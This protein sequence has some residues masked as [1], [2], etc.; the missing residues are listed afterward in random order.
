MLEIAGI[1]MVTSVGHDVKTSCASIRAGITRS[2]GINHFKINSGDSYVP[3]SLTAC[4]ISNLTDG[5]GTVPRWSIMA[6]AALHDLINYSKLPDL[7][8]KEF[9]KKTAVVFATPSIDSIHFEFEGVI[10]QENA[11][12]VY[13]LPFIA[14]SGLMVSY[15]KCFI[16]DEDGT[17]VIK[18][19]EV[20]RELLSKNDVDF[21]IILATD[22]NIEANIL[23]LLSLCG[24]LKTSENPVGLTPGE[25]AAA[26]L[27]TSDTTAKRFKLNILATITAFTTKVEKN[28]FISEVPNQGDALASSVKETFNSAGV[29]DRFIGDIFSDLNGE[30]WRAQEYGMMRVKNCAELSDNTGNL[31]LPATSLGDIG[32]VHIACS[33]CMFVETKK[34]GYAKSDKALILSSSAMGNTG[35]VLIE[36]FNERE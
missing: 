2:C 3:I 32:V 5:F 11:L 7:H 13:V 20:A 18:A 9:W 15:D 1:G 19:L 28:N 14:Q 36:S 26:L 31:K 17:A 10:N 34:R 35:S 24:R 33:I 22:S 12:E 29:N 6:S 4:P 21:V 25:G 23:S 8:Q 30:L 27:L 16:V